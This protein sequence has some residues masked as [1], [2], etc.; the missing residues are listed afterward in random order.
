VIY[1]SAAVAAALRGQLRIEGGELALRA[2][3]VGQSSPESSPPE[4]PE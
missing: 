3:V 4:E 1:R 2:P